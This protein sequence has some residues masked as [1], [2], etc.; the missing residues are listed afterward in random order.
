MGSFI[1]HFLRPRN[2]CELSVD[3]ED[4]RWKFWDIQFLFIWLVVHFFKYFILWYLY[5]SLIF[6]FK[7]LKIQIISTFVLLLLR[8]TCSQQRSNPET[9]IVMMVLSKWWWWRWWYQNDYDDYYDQEI[10]LV[11]WG[12]WS[13]CDNWEL[14]IQWIQFS[15][16]PP[17][18]QPS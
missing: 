11:W 1:P 13:V 8:G 15:L 12:F 7:I 3:L 5:M 16:L 17:S 9:K 6:I 4:E 10:L 18:R 2:Q 14:G